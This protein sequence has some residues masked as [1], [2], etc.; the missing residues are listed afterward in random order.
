MILIIKTVVLLA[1][2]SEQS[3]T[4]LGQ[5]LEIAYKANVQ[6]HALGLQLKQAIQL[7]APQAQERSVVMTLNILHVA[8][9]AVPRD[10]GRME[11]GGRTDNA[12]KAKELE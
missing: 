5:H 6:D 4:E 3:L 1:L 11:L 7:T 10:L 12:H 8:L 9:L 2:L